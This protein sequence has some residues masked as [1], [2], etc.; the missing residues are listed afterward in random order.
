MRRPPL[1]TWCV[2]VGSRSHQRVTKRQPVA[3]EHDHTLFLGG[4]QFSNAEAAGAQRLDDP[5]QVAVTFGRGDHQGVEHV[6][7]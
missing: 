4:L 1:A 2:V 6:R 3:V 5:Q 7:R